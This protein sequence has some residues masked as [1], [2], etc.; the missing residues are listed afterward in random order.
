M[1]I[2]LNVNSVD[3]PGGLQDTA[4]SLRQACGVEGELEREPIATALLNELDA[5]YRLEDAMRTE[6]LREAEE[7]SVLL[8]RAIS[9]RIPGG[10][11][12]RGRFLGLGEGGEL[13]IQDESGR[14][15]GY[16]AV[17]NVQIIG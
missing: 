6:I 9:F 1:G 16:Q 15:Q 12:V 10:R 17:E 11:M 4:I 7:R 13:R 8:N 14:R 3:F 2:G 5:V